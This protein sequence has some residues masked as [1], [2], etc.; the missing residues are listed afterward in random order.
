VSLVVV[1]A[2]A[3][4]LLVAASAAGATKYIDSFIG[5]QT[6]T[7]QTVGGGFSTGG[8]GVGG[9]A[10]HDSTGAVYVVDRG[11]HRIQQFDA[12]NGFVRAWGAGVVYG[13]AAGTGTTTNGS[14]S[15]TS[16][17]STAGVFIVGQTV[18]GAGIPPNTKITA[19]SATT[20]T[21]SQPATA[22]S[23]GV[24]LTVVAGT[25]NVAV[26]EQQTVTIGGAPTGGTF[27]LIWN[28]GTGNQTAAGIPFNASAAD[29]QTAL[30]GLAALAPGDVSVTSSNPGGGAMAG[31][32]YAVEFTGNRADTDVA[33]ITA[34]ATGLTPVGSPTKTVTI[35]TPVIGASAPEVCTVADDCKAGLTTG[36]TGIVPG[37]GFNTPQ[38]IAVNQ[39]TGAV[40]VT[41]GFNFRIQQFTA[42]GLF[43]RAWGQDVI[44]TSA[45]NDTGTTALEGCDAT[46][47]NTASD[48]KT[49]TTGAT[50]GAFASTFV[51]YPAVVPASAPNGGNLLVADPG[52]RRVQEFTPTGAFVRTFGYDVATGGGTGFEICSSAIACKAGVAGNAVGQFAAGEPKRVAA[53]A[54][55]AIYTT[56]IAI[57][58]RA[59]KF[60]EA[61][62]SASIFA[63]G[64]LGGG[65][66][67]A[68][69]PSDIVFDAS[70]NR[71]LVARGYLTTFAPHQQFFTDCVNA[72]PAERRIL[73][74]SPAGVLQDTHGACAGVGVGAASPTPNVGLA[75][76]STTG[77]LY[78]SST[79][80][81][82][83]NNLNR[84]YVLDADGITSAISAINPAT[85]VTSDGADLSGTVNP[86]SVDNSFAPTTW[87]L[88]VS[89]NGLDWSSLATGTLAAGTTAS[90]VS[91]SMSGLRPN[92]LYRT[93]VV[94]S[95]PF[96]NPEISS[97]EL[98]FLTDAVAP[99]VR[100][101]VAE[102]LQPTGATLSAR[103][104]PHGTE[105][106]YRFE[107]GQGGFQHIVPVP[108]GSVGSGPD[109]VKV[110]QQLA[111]LQPGTAYQ[112]RAVVVSV[113]QGATVGP[114]IT[115]TTPTQPTGASGRAYELVSPPD[116]I[117]GSGLGTWYAGIGSHGKAGIAAYEGDRYASQSYY[118]AS[119]ADGGFS[120]GG[121]WTLGQ[122]TPT[123]WVNK[124][125]LN[126]KGGAGH[127]QLGVIPEIGSMS[128][129][130]SL[131][132]WGA[133]SHLRIFEEMESVFGGAAI[134]GD[135][136]RE[137]ES[138]R[139]ELIGPVDPTQTWGGAEAIHATA[140]AAG[141]GY[142]VTW[143]ELHGLAG[144]GDP[145]HPSFSGDPGYLV[146]AGQSVYIDDVTAGLSDTFPG[147][148]IRSLVN[149]C[150]G[151]GADG[152]AIP[153][154]DGGGKLVAEECPV[155]LPGR[156][157]RLVSP[158][159]ASLGAEGKAPNVISA[160]GSRVFF[161]SPDLS[162][163]M[164]ANNAACSGTGSV[165]TVCP[166]QVYVR[167]RNT[168]G[169]VTTRWISQSMVSGQGASLTAAAEFEGAT[170]DG[171][172]V[173]FRTASPL[174]ADDPNGGVQ[175][176]DG[177]KTGTP[178]PSSVD[179]YMYDLP[180]G[181][182]GDPA[183]TD[184]DPAG[185]TLTRISAGPSGDG[186]ANVSTG[187]TGQDGFGASPAGTNGALR[188]FGKD[189]HT[190]YFVT[191]A[192]LPGVPA[193]SNGT[194]TTPGGTVGQTA[195]KN[196]YVYDSDRP[197][198][199]RWRFI[200]RLPVTPLGRC[201]AVGSR[202]D[203]DGLI[204]DGAG[205]TGLVEV[206]L[207][208]ANCVRGVSEGSFVTLFTD[209]ALTADDP[210]S[211]T[212]DVYAYDATAD[213]LTRI[214]A[215]KGGVGGS[216]ECVNDKGNTAGV[217]TQ[218]CFGDPRVSGPAGNPPTLG[219]VTS[220]S[221]E[222]VVFF[223]SASRL[224]A[225]DLNDVYDV[226]QWRNGELSLISTGAAGAHDALYRGNDREGVNVYFSTRGRLTWQ[227]HDAVLDV[228][229]ARV[230]GGISQPSS[231][232]VCALLAD[233]C[234][235]EGN[236]PVAVAPK[237]TRP[238]DRNA[239]SGARTEVSM[240]RL[241]AAAKR[242]AVRRGVLAVPVRVT[243]A[244]VVTA[245]V[246]GRIGRRARR[247]GRAS[248]GFSKAG[249][250][251]LEVRLSKAVRK[252]LRLGRR[253]R[254]G[255][256]VTSPGTRRRSVTVLLKGAR[257]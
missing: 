78:V 15:V 193:P 87:K 237:S 100:T 10:V 217:E 249:R 38:G 129:D 82:I 111:G 77:R 110:T 152:T 79:T 83:T 231:P 234:Q 148:G 65:A 101:T 48:C 14:T 253:L 220:S 172:K 167:Q 185:G 122:R 205:V 256:S 67:E 232:P 146:N 136:L 46:A 177:V 57:N 115:F 241:S 143:G 238:G 108:D 92:T 214:S 51:G 3:V 133:A 147:E 104:N 7:N 125:G 61:A 224:V 181:P 50:G 32:P 41:D 12:S 54:T 121:D 105:T 74:L 192:P 178:N 71:V 106:S 191:A 207:V 145:T 81:Q 160:D 163:T 243:G 119:L 75:I 16:W 85:N 211:V 23:A 123:G 215:P 183:T 34:S 55:G 182:D 29:V 21:L 223:E 73:E 118:G 150:T 236:P 179:L 63:A 200:A 19:V 20:L 222:R 208:G 109:F 36:G 114:T 13:A 89:R 130:M 128:D 251:T 219:L 195:F 53:D 45:P 216:Y 102:D 44:K 91:G 203:S 157:A 206:D 31:G 59:Q 70:A 201:A 151:S 212:G 240:G 66:T 42:S 142:A 233:G 210:D 196:L 186:D 60:T 247:V 228:Y 95:K 40:Y 173:F 35:A 76:R 30:E 107:W 97:A 112:F 94:T 6:A 168:D 131:M 135:L 155:A 62:L 174:T 99:E 254:L 80:T 90:V 229:V 11:N 188:F 252:Q 235:G 244:G 72:A 69:A 138:G 170:P 218:R 93:R 250:A 28:P 158:R 47:G 24:A 9:V 49:G 255:V 126:R 197:V 64:D 18:T 144:P 204:S 166:P 153:S 230:G 52:N 242:R 164:T 175:L 194:I 1:C 171:D 226:Y 39:A 124:P 159:G 8:G 37:G 227:D 176:P 245:T 198:G 127:N 5:N 221:G 156:D 257:R 117:G 225:E 120:Y 68:G 86:N 103:V 116:K 84:V 149:V 246:I 96:A 165:G 187:S 132:L 139:W 58:F 213:E 239:S 113:T 134:D 209:G 98:T 162:I 189:G 43:V 33:Q 140:V 190:V 248:R 22:S 137:W 4:G 25:G 199:L 180:D 169:S 202:P 26:N 56:E 154:V 161:V 184:G 27:S 2:V 17:A 141:G 88:Q